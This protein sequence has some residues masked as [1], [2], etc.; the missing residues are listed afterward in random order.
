[1]T[2]RKLHI[3]DQ[4]WTWR[5]SGHSILIRSPERE[6]HHAYVYDLRGVRPT[7]T[8]RDDWKGNLHVM[9]REVKEYIRVKLLG[10][11]P[12][13]TSDQYG[14]CCGGVYKHKGMAGSRRRFVCTGCERGT[15]ACYLCDKPRADWGD[16]KQCICL[17]CGWYYQENKLPIDQEEKLWA[18]A[19]GKF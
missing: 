4:V 8:E 13:D 15:L 7:D 19:E 16:T 2:E 6:K 10:L 9:P 1:M 18:L 14:C 11:P 12:E 3:G 5:Y 17:L